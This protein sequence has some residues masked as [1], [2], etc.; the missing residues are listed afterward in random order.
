VQKR[1][2]ERKEVKRKKRKEKRWKEI[3]ISRVEEVISLNL[4]LHLLWNDLGVKLG[5]IVEDYKTLLSSQE[6][7]AKM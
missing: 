7:V 1:N 2:E 5:E 4:N 3:K 6:I